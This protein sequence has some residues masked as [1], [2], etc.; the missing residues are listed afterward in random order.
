VPAL[1]ISLTLLTDGLQSWCTLHYTTDSIN[2]LSLQQQNVF[3]N[4]CT[5]FVNEYAFTSSAIL[6]K[7]LSIISIVFLLFQ[8]ILCAL[9]VE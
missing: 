5:G 8:S 2:S 7:A 6:S 1:E 4:K 3:L 9:F